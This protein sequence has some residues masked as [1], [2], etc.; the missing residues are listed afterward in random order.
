MDNQVLPEVLP[1]TVDIIRTIEKSA[2]KHNELWSKVANKYSEVEL[3]LIDDTIK[4]TYQII[5]IIGVV[6]GFGFTGIGAV[7]NISFFLA[8]EVVMMA[9]IV[10]GIYNIKKF[11]TSN[12]NSIQKASSN[13][14]D[15]FYKTSAFFIKTIEDS[16]K[17]G[18][19]KYK[20]FSEKL[21]AANKEL[22]LEFDTKRKT[23]K[24]E[25]DFLEYMIV[26]FSVGFLLLIL[27]F[28]PKCKF[29]I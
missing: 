16:A 8:G 13:A 29:W 21:N 24:N 5:T 23:D 14:K 25:E 2:H 12:I 10:V 27:S 11:Y 6:G 28:L 19:L 9:S 26:L 15:K 22:L 4:F 3:K 20:E 18:K 7:K 1:L 17:T